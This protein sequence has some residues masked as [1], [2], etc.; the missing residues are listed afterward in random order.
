LF[1]PLSA[2]GAAERPVS[3]EILSIKRRSRETAL[4]SPPMRSRKCR[5]EAVKAKAHD[6][7]ETT[8]DGVPLRT[9]L[10]E[11]GVPLATIRMRGE[12][13]A[14]YLQVEAA[15]G[16]R[17]IF[18]LPEL[19][20]DFA[21]RPIILADRRDGQGTGREGKARCASSSATRPGLRDG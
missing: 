16:Y 1:F 13:L 8:Y 6:G 4:A 21:D 3:G 5:A 10:A 2:T 14:L 19:D 20:D 12:N 15:D 7:K 9:I 18:A 17:A 11:A